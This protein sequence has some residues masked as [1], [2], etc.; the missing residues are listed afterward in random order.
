[1]SSDLRRNP[2]FEKIAYGIVLQYD[3]NQSGNN[4]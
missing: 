1:V 3:D 4:Y 2:L